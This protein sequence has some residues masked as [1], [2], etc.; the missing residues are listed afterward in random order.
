[1]TKINFESSSFKDNFGKVFYYKDRVFRKLTAEGRENYLKTE[2][3][4]KESIKK[5]F[6][7]ETKLLNEYAYKEFE[8]NSN[9]SIILEH[10]K[11]PFI[12]YS[13]EWCFDQL[14]SAAIHHLDFQI[15]LLKEGYVLRDANSFNVQ[16]LNGKPIFIDCMSIRPYVHEE[17]WGGYNQFCEF[18]LNPLL[19]S[20]TIDFDYNKILKGS[21]HGISTI[22][23]NNIIPFVKKLKPSLFLHLYL[24]SYYEKKN[25]KNKD[26]SLNRFKKKIS[27]NSYLYLLKNLRKIILKLHKY[28]SISF[29]GKYNDF[30]NYDNQDLDK[31]KSILESLIKQKLPTSVLDLGCNDGLF[32]KI[33][34][35]ILIKNKKDANLVSV[36][37]DHDCIQKV[38]NNYKN[39]SSINLALI[40]DF[41]D[42]SSNLG[43]LENER[44]GF[45]KRFNF[46]C[47][48]AYAII[49]HLIIGCNI[50]IKK[51][52][53]FI[54]KNSKFGLIEFI[55]K[56]DPMILKMLE[57][58]DDVFH[59]YNTDTL[60]DIFKSLSKKFTIYEMI[61][62]K[63]IIYQYEDI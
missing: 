60:E 57:N 51:L 36:D 16:F 11:I 14:K 44:S 9:N 6:L 1:M 34:N 39:C 61:N 29:W 38:F 22:D 58:R 41:S 13:Y 45:I 10:K 32:S 30:N 48:I 43:F 52:L 54:V 21:V 23:A 20:S 62:S 4:I 56:E 5:E 18:F 17:Y 26:L 40:Q 2:D 47:I 24:K 27:K 8:F 33:V 46:N 28:R 63:R 55:P 49:H 7:I 25:I 50:P 37:I 53:N 31:K 3:I 19:I 42:P 59:D 12:S 15:F 35:D